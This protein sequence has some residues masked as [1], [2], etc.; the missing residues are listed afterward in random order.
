MGRCLYL[1]NIK[2][3]NGFPRN[4]VG[5]AKYFRIIREEEEPV[6]CGI[7]SSCWMKPHLSMKVEEILLWAAGTCG[8]LAMGRR[9]STS[10]ELSSR[11]NRSVLCSEPDAGLRWHLLPSAQA[12][13]CLV[14]QSCPALCDPM[15]Y[16]P[17]RRLCPWGSPGK[18]AGVGCHALLQGIFAMQGSNPG[19]LHCRWNLYRLS[20]QFRQLPAFLASG[21]RQRGNRA[22][23]STPR[24]DSRGT[25]SA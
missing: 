21:S 14:G 5:V 13:L 23:S 8:W 18:N 11:A 22:G 2:I 1:Y 4:A 15:N 6:R 16:R 25:G 24:A 3:S 12:V 19:L 7:V 17:P 10:R 9:G 20:H